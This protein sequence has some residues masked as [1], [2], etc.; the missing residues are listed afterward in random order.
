MAE[1][2]LFGDPRY[3]E[4]RFLNFSYTPVIGPPIE[5]VRLQLFFEYSFNLLISTKDLQALH[6]L[7]SP[8]TYCMGAL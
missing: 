6:F 2:Y 4:N 7:K 1:A 8:H 3:S 5:L